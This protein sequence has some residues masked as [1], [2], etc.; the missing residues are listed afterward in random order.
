MHQDEHAVNII[1]VGGWMNT[2]SCQAQLVCL[3]VNAFAWLPVRLRHQ[4]PFVRIKGARLNIIYF[5]LNAKVL[6]RR[7]VYFLLLCVPQKS[8]WLHLQGTDPYHSLATKKWWKKWTFWVNTVRRWEDQ[9]LFK[10]CAPGDHISKPGPFAV[11]HSH[12]HAGAHVCGYARSNAVF[13]RIGSFHLL[14][15]EEIDPLKSPK[16]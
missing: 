1:R 9:Y 15:N 14:A 8:S 2:L 13:I 16:T 3:P 12:I 5:R 6:G 4:A 7:R 10:V 11:A